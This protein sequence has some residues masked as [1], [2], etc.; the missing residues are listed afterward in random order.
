MGERLHN[1]PRTKNLAYVDQMQALDI[2]ELRKQGFLVEGRRKR[3]RIPTRLAPAGLGL[4]VDL[5]KP[6]DP[7]VLVE[8]PGGKGHQQFIGLRSRETPFGGRR[9][10]FLDE[11][12]HL[13]EKLYLVGRNFVSR[14]FAGLTYRSQSAGALDRLLH[15]RAWLHRRLNGQGSRGPARGRVRARLSAELEHIERIIDLVGGA[16]VRAAEQAERTAWKRR[17]ASKQRLETALTFMRQRQE[18]PATEVVARFGPLLDRLK[19]EEPP[20]APL[21]SRSPTPQAIAPEERAHVDIVTLAR[22]GY[23]KEG[24]RLG[25]QLGWPED[26]LPQPGRRLFFLVDAREHE[27]MCALFILEDGDRI[28]HQFFWLTRVEGVFGRQEYRFVCPPD[29]A[30]SRTL[31]YEAG[32]FVCPRRPEPVEPSEPSKLR[33]CSTLMSPSLVQCSRTSAGQRTKARRL[34]PC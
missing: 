25:D 14:K 2:R 11:V 12:G 6:G 31:L 34:S 8:V 18:M 19:Q 28:E 16:P 20:R 24:Q 10:F 29:H 33:R 4:I 3:G 17:E 30:L 27:R 15:R 7:H 22:L 5:V 9:W 23:V 21:A 26:W 32:R 13:C 1:N